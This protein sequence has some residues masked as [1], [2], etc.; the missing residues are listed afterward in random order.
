MRTALARADTGTRFTAYSQAL[1]AGW[2]TVADVR[3]AESLPF[4]DGTDQLNRPANVSVPPEKRIPAMQETQLI[5]SLKTVNE[6]G[7]FEGLAAVYGNR[8]AGG[9]T[10]AHWRL[11]QE[12]GREE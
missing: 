11:H 1:T 6:D 9:D 8:D 4:I 5:L 2:M 12:P 7:T 10:I 3:E